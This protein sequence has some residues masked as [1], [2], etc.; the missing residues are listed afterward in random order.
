MIVY[1]N[2]QPMT[3]A[4]GHTLAQLLADINAQAPFAAA[5]NQTFVPKGRYADTVLQA[6]DHIDVVQPVVGG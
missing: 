6:D 2:H 1:L 4:D 5:I 3:V